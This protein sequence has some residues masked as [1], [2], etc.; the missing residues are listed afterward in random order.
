MIPTTLQKSKKPM[1]WQ[2]FLLGLLT[3]AAFFI[4]YIALGEGYFLFYGDFNVQQVPFYQLCHN[5]IR[6]GEIGWNWSTDL[7]VNFIGSY[8]FYLLGSPF[9]W[10]TLPFP[11]SFVPYL[12]GPLLIL[13]FATASMTAYFYLRRFVRNSESAVLG[14]ILYAFSGFSVYNVFFNHFHEAIVIFPLLLLAMEMHIVDRRRGVFGAMVFV[15]AVTNYFFFFGMVVFAVIY[16]T[17]RITHRCWKQ[18]IKSFLLMAFEAIIGLLMSMAILL[19]TVFA[20]LQNDRLSSINL[21]YNSWL[22]GRVQIYAN[23]LQIFFFPPDIPARPVFFP[24]ADIKWS[25]MGAWLPLFSMVGVFAFVGAKK[26]NW[27]S[28]ILKICLFMALVPILNSAFYMFNSAYYARWIYMPIL[29]MCLATVMAIE[30]N[31]VSWKSSFKWVFAITAVTSLII[32]LWPEGKN[33]DGSITHLGIYT[34]EEN[35]YTYIARYWV[36]CGIALASLVILGILLY[37][38]RKYHSIFIKNSLTAVCI[39]SVIYSAVFIGCGKS[40][41]YDIHNE[42][43]PHLIEGELDL[44]GNPD[45]FRIDC[46][47]CMDNTAMFLGYSGINAFHSIVPGSVM[48]FYEY[49]GEERSVASR[50]ETDNYALRS[51]LSVKYLLSREGGDSFVDDEGDTLMPYWKFVKKENSFN[52]YKNDYYLPYGFT[53]DTYISREECDEVAEEHRAEMMVKS[54]VLDKKQIKKYAKRLGLEDVNTEGYFLDELAFEDDVKAR[55][56]TAAYDFKRNKNG[57]TAKID[58]KK[59]NLVFFSVPYE[60]GWTAYVNGSPVEIERVNVGFMAVLAPE[61]DVTIEFRY[62]TPGLILGLIVSVFALFVFVIYLLIVKI[63]RQHH[64][65]KYKGE[66]PE[67]EEL[68][69]YWENNPEPLPPAP[70]PEVEDTSHNIGEEL[71]D[72]DT[73]I[74]LEALHKFIDEPKEGEDNAEIL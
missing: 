29:I 26:K 67:G 8:S 9:F 18:S 36:T 57:F 54:I 25:S 71:Y 37:K 74:D 38:Y 14:G 72:D 32:G 31:N 28:R 2:T 56:K 5:A 53:Y 15:A 68:F 47:E 46:Y 60:K 12:M 55:A 30:D 39:V 63:Y 13:K 43:I 45:T 51:L 58:L 10:L 4:P 48:E 27:I 33:S 42:V 61:G 65:V 40:H 66:W 7:G 52:V 20:V 59:E 62:T 24:G 22:Y 3:A 1:H 19:P 21:G 50:P 34:Y 64:P 41:S 16:W 49:V 11:N 17:I 73:T 44:E 70:E 35:S 23:I 6:S 69:T